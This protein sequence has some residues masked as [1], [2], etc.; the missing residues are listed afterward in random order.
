MPAKVKSNVNPPPK[1]PP[2]KPAP[3]LPG[4]SDPPKALCY[5]EI[6]QRLDACAIS[7]KSPVRVRITLLEPLFGMKREVFFGVRDIVYT[8]GP[9]GKPDLVELI[10]Q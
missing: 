5:G 10:V 9:Q 8:P 2:P 6:Q 3:V 4:L 1:N 7:D